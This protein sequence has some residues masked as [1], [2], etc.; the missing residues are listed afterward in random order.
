MSKI[1]DVKRERLTASAKS[2][3]TVALKTD[4][5]ADKSI[6]CRLHYKKIRKSINLPALSEIFAGLTYPSILG[7]NIAKA[8]ADRFSYWA[9]CPKEI[10]EFRAGEKDP[11][12]KLQKAIDKYKL[13][14]DYDVDSRLRGNDKGTFY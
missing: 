11:F 4:V 8:D 5:A 12:G 13:E 2:R 1:Q 7:G 10:F 9:A 3:R 14:I 6:L